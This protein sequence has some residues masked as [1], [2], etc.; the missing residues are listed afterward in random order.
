MAHTGDRNQPI[1]STSSTTNTPTLPP[2]SSLMNTH[3]D[4]TLDRMGWPTLPH[5]RDAWSTVDLSVK[6]ED[7]DRQLMV[8]FTKLD[9]GFNGLKHSRV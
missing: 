5:E 3:Q 4:M 6:Q 7:A 1:T 9:I 2:Y 8:V